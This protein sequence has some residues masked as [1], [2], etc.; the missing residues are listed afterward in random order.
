MAGQAARGASSRAGLAASLLLHVAFVGAAILSLP[1]RGPPPDPRSFEVSLVP[2]LPTVEIVRKRPPR[3]A[4]RAAQAAVPAPAIPAVVAIAP[5][6]IIAPA[7]PSAAAGEGQ[8]M[9]KVRALLRGSV[10]CS[11]AR[12]A[13]LSQE[14]LDR[15]A[16]WRQAHID[17]NL[18]IPAPIAPEKRAWFEAVLA[19]RKAPDH[20]PGF[21][22]GMLINGIHLV[23]PKTPPHAL[24]L[25]PLPCYV[26][27][28]KWGITEEADVQ[29]PSRKD[30]EG[31]TLDYAPAI[32]LTN[33]KGIG[34]GAHGP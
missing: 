24:K 32:P 23:K 30:S 4:R 34:P 7:A 13:H 5:E 6:A 26:V 27:P 2:P 8:A 19:S 29:P 18:Q 14:E 15:C 31:K 28:P 17:P 12:F 10:G 21:V 3:A 16:K 33:A 22:C 20:P 1:W 9:G 11:E 25:G